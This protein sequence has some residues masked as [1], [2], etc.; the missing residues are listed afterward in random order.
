VTTRSAGIVTLLSCEDGAGPSTA[1]PSFAQALKKSGATAVW[2]YGR[3]VDAAEPSSAT[4]KF[5]ENIR[6][7]K[8][9]LESLRSL[10][11]DEGVKAGPGVHLKAQ[12]VRT[13][14]TH[15]NSSNQHDEQFEFG[16]T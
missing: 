1:G 10:S 16:S 15:S 12:L 6:G 9:P 14:S 11:R 3:R 5:L 13:G 4:S 2:S 7:G 8:S